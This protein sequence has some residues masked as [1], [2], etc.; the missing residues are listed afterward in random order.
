MTD[1]ASVVCCYDKCHHNPSSIH[2]LIVV[3]FANAPAFFVIEKPDDPM[4]LM[5]MKWLRV[6]ALLPAR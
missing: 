6:K 1:F 3:S 5:Y 4:L 2:S